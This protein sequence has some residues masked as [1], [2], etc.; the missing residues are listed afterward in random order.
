MVLVLV[1]VNI[2]LQNTVVVMAEMVVIKQ[3]RE[4]INLFFI[5]LTSVG[6]SQVCLNGAVFKS[7]RGTK[8]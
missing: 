5:C 3:K 7:T 2:F 6:D 8:K 4:I 1:V